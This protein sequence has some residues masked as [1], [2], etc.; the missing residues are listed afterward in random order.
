MSGNYTGNL[1]F[2]YEGTLV[3]LSSGNTTNWLISYAPQAYLAMTEAFVKA[4]E[5]DYA[6]AAALKGD[7]RDTLD[8]LTKQSSVMQQGR[9]SVT[10]PGP[11]P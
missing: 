7:A 8:E 9:G 4:R 10:I 3:G 5:G 1:T 11:T 2:D 6:S